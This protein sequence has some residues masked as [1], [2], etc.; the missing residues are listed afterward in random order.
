MSSFFEKVQFTFKNSNEKIILLTA[1]REILFSPHCYFRMDLR[2]NCLKVY[3]KILSVSIKYFSGK[4]YAYEDWIYSCIKEENY[5]ERGDYLSENSSETHSRYLGS[6]RGGR[7]KSRLGM[8]DGF[9]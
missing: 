9:D 1:L 3:E 8:D 4:K 6:S 7:N 5:E 2:Q